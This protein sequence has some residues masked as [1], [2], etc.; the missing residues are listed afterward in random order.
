METTTIIYSQALMLLAGAVIAA[1]LFKRLGLGTI[2]GYL[3]AGILIGPVAQQIT[4][5]EEILHVSEL[6]VVFLLFII[7]L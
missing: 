3:A 7:G 1:P 6:G 4:E 2:L 5:G